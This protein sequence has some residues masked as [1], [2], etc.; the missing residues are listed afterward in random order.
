MHLN[1]LGAA[2]HLADTKCVVTYEGMPRSPELSCWWP[3]LFYGWVVAGVLY[4]VHLRARNPVVKGLGAIDVKV[5]LAAYHAGRDLYIAEAGC[6][7]E[8]VARLQV[9]D[10]DC[11]RRRFVVPLV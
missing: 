4:P 2:G 8:S 11:N 1:I 9:P 10:P 6:L 3:G 5:F 7:V